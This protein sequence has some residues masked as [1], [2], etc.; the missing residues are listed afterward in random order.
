MPKNNNILL[1]IG[2]A[3]VVA[4]VMGWISLPTFGGTDG[5]TSDLYPST[6]K[7]S[8][9]LNT[10]DLLATSATDTN[11]SYYVF[12]SAGN[13][14]KEGTTA[15]GTA[16]FDV[17]SGVSG[18]KL[19]VY[20]DSGYADEVDYLPKVVDFSTTAENERAVKTINVDVY[21]ESNVTL[22]K[23]RDPVDLDSNISA[24]A[25][26]NVA[27]D[28]LFQTQV[29]NAATNK[30]VIVVDVNSTEIETVSISGLSTESCPD[31]LAVTGG[32]KLYCFGTGIVLLSSDGLK[33]YSGTFKVDAAT[34]PST[35]SEAI[36][37][38]IDTGLY[39]E[40][41]YKTAGFSAFK[42]GTENPIT[43]VDIGASDSVTMQLDFAG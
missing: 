38:V 11:I 30:P 24:T 6:L 21:R 40:S 9:T 12:D 37:T 23:V 17:P 27:F 19:L 29:A 16:S 33:S 39:R 41:D 32:R 31:R 3:V 10:G 20:D 5:D 15:S 14:L 22:S 34:T 42:Y 26:S 13:Y 18:Y 28:I 25:G 8:I 4:L 43:N 2:A 1:L 36:F 7:T 35:T